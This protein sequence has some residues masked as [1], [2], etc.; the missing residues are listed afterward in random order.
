[1][2]VVNTILRRT[3]AGT[4]ALG[5]GLTALVTLGGPAQAASSVRVANSQGAAVADPT[6]ATTVKVSGAGFQSIK[7]GRGGIY[8]FFGTVK[9]G[10]RP[11]QGGITGK[12]YFYV[13]DTESAKNHGYQ[14]YVAFAGSSTAAE[15]N[16]GTMS[17][18]GGWS[19]TMTVPGAVFKAADRNGKATTIDCTKVQCGIITVGAHGLN[20]ANNE[21]FTPVRFVE[22][23][24]T[25][26]TGS[27]GSGDAGSAT[28]GTD[29]SSDGSSTASDPNT[30]GGPASVPP[31]PGPRG[32]PRLAIDRA[33]A[34]A[35][36]ALSFRAAGLTPGRQVTVVL[37]D[38]AAAAGPFLVA[39][40]GTFAGVL[41]VPAAIGGGTHELR[42]FGINKAPT[43]NFAVAEGAAPTSD[44]SAL[45]SASTTSKSA[46]DTTEGRFAIGLTGLAAL[47]VVV[48]GGRLFT[49][50][51][52]RHA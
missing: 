30:T 33:S 3:A 18:N 15:A 25:S 42:V 24:A 13:P 51:R 7:G 2:R 28:D 17:A 5:L 50:R 41:Q 31:A 14:K 43:L 37:D 22:G 38:G 27:S 47:L 12:D 39:A 36:A 32:K 45:A 4:A 23:T 16:G 11:S 44:A 20:N 26:Q 40:D 49:S 21:T 19:T 1:M 35:G 8:L 29:Q 6:Y 52:R 46:V 48:A 10:W 9:G 34:R